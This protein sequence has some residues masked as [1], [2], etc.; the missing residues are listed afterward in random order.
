MC[1]PCTRRIKDAVKQTRSMRTSEF[2]S[3]SNAPEL[4]RGAECELLNQIAWGRRRLQLL[5]RW[6]E[7]RISCPGPS[8]AVLP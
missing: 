1:S 2:R 3:L 5:V 7:Y 4:S 6:R 8:S